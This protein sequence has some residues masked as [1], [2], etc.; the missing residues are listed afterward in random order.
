M[1]I[2]HFA[3]ILLVFSLYTL[4]SK[5]LNVEYVYSNKMLLANILNI[6]T[7]DSVI[8][9]KLTELGFQSCKLPM[10]YLV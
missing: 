9:H 7:L 1:T 8:N 6:R 4:F 2:L 3:E 5:R 10:V